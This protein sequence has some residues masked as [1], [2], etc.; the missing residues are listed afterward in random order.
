MTICELA[1]GCRQLGTLMTAEQM[2]CTLQLCS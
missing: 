1:G 2:V